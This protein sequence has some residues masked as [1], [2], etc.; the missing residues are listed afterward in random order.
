MGN[1]LGCSTCF[2]NNVEDYINFYFYNGVI[3]N[4]I[5]YNSFTNLIKKRKLLIGTNETILIGDFKNIIQHGLIL[6]SKNSPNFK[7][8]ETAKFTEYI[9]LDVYNFIDS[10]NRNNLYTILLLIFPL[11]SKSITKKNNKISEFFNLLK[12]SN[13]TSSSITNEKYLKENSFEITKYL[14]QSKN[15]PLKINFNLFNQNFSFF[16]STILIGYSLP[17]KNY[18]LENNYESLSMQIKKSFKNCLTSKNLKEFYNIITKDLLDSIKKDAKRYQVSTNLYYVDFEMFSM[19]FE[20]NL[21][22]LD[23]KEVRSKFFNMFYTETEN[24]DKIY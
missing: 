22:L 13:V 16:I 24:D 19:F 18:F 23:F 20:R 8:S 11:I 14:N 6:N 17:I 15:N 10:N 21:Y 5:D 7:N 9:L 2:S 12:K 3:I 1:S 4:N